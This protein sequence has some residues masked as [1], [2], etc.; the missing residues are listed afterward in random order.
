MTIGLQ[1]HCIAIS[2]IWERLKVHDRNEM[3][4]LRK[5]I[6]NG[7]KSPTPLRQQL[8]YKS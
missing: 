1:N 3:F 7:A 8:R 5:E 6:E 2:I 4:S